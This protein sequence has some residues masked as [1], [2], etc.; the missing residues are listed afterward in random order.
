[1]AEGH[2]NRFRS[3]GAFLIKD[4]AMSAARILIGVS[5]GAAVGTI[6][7][8][9]SVGLPALIGIST[10][11]I[12]LTAMAH[13][14]IQ[15]EKKALLLDTYREEL[16]HLL[17]KD[18]KQL[19]VKDLEAAAKSP[20]N[21]QGS[22]AIQMALDY[23]TDTRNFY[24]GTQAITA[25][26]MVGGLFAIKAA[27][28]EEAASGVLSPAAL[29][30]ASGLLYNEMFKGFS[31]IASLFYDGNIEGTIT[32]DIRAITEQISLGGR[33]SS[34]RV[35]GVMVSADD[36]LQK[37]VMDQFG[38]PYDQLSI[39]DN[40]E[41]FEFMHMQMQMICSFWKKTVAVLG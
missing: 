17:G 31:N 28:P 18:D 22:T 26:T 11:I 23:F 24:I 37:R 13:T 36:D 3:I 41:H 19:T 1:M 8:S 4:G 21:L 35:L 20:D 39:A 10:A 32:K 2:T 34:T 30:G 25:A 38:Q 29:S 40:S 15:R 12:G 33:I 6:G 27:F 14:S 16:G 5:L 7:T 9:I